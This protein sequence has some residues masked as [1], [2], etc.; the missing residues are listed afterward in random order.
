[1]RILFSIRDGTNAMFEE[2]DV[3]LT[4]AIE[5]GRD[6]HWIENSDRSPQ[7]TWMGL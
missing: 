3:K 1:M 7:D 4:I 2:L 5:I 6:K